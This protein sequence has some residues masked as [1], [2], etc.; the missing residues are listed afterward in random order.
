[1]SINN[2]FSEIII[3]NNWIYV[4]NELLCWMEFNNKQKYVN[5]I[6]KEFIENK[7]F[8]LINNKEFSKFDIDTI[9]I[10]KNTNIKYHNKIKHLIISPSTFKKSL[11]ILNTNKSK[12]VKEYF[13]DVEKQLNDLLL[14]KNININKN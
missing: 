3:N 7:D 5:I 6:K 11:M 2:I 1:M 14:I 9:N 12:Q 8:K 4:N 13:L 10:Y